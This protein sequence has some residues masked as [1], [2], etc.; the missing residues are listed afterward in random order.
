MGVL[1]GCLG[2]ASGGSFGLF[3]SFLG[4]SFCLL[5]WWLVGVLGS[6]RSSVG[7]SAASGLGRWCPFRIAPATVLLVGVRSGCASLVCLFRVS[8]VCV[9]SGC[10]PHIFADTFKPDICSRFRYVTIEK[11]KK[12]NK[13]VLNN[14]Y[15]NF[16]FHV[17]GK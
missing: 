11:T 8:G 4:R 17:L 2:S 12:A 3:G 10:V 14:P 1:S 16:S 9:W 15:L 6:G 13:T 7:G 5:C